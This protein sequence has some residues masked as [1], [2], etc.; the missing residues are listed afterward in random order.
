METCTN[1]GRTIFEMTYDNN[2]VRF[3]VYIPANYPT[4]VNLNY[5]QAV[6]SEGA[7]SFYPGCKKKSG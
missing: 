6:A 4:D 7:S 2:C 3:P 1:I 5:N